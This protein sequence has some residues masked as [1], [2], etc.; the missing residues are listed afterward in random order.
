LENRLRNIIDRLTLNVYD[1]TCLGIFGRHILIFSFQMTSMILEGENLLNK[2]ELDFF[3]KGN[4]SLEV[5]QR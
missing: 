2:L 1:Y 5:V 4:T 3:L